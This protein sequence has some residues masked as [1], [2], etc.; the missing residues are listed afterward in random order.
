MN[1]IYRL[2]WNEEQRRWVAAAE[3]AKGRTRRTSE[4]RCVRR[5][6][7]GVIKIFAGLVGLAMSA[8]YAAIPVPSALPSGAQVVQGS[9]ALNITANQ[10]TVSQS[11]PKAVI[12]WGSFDIGSQAQVRFNQ[13]DASSIALNRIVG[14]APSQI[15]G[16]LQANGQVF[17]INPNGVIFGR[18]AQVDVHGLLASTLDLADADFMAGRLKFSGQARSVRNDGA[19]RTDGQT[20]GYVA[21][22]GGQVKNSGTIT[23]ELGSVVLA[24]GAE[25]TLDFTGNGL[26]KVAVSTGVADALVEQAGSVQADGGRVQLTA[27]AANVLVDAM[28][29]TT[30]LTQAHGLQTQNG[31]IELT[32]D[33]IQIGATAVLDASGAMGGGT[34]HVGGGW[35]GS[36]NQLQARQTTVEAGARI[37]ASATV[38]GPGGEIVVWSDVHQLGSVTRVQGDLRATGAGD[39]SHGGRI[40]TSGHQL[41]TVGV[42]GSAAA[43]QNGVAGLWLFDPADYLIDNTVNNVSATINSLLDSGTSVAISTISGNNFG[44][45][46]TAGM[47]N[48][49]VNS[50][51]TKSKGTTT[52]LT[53]QAANSIEINAAIKNTSTSGLMHVVLDADNDRDGNGFIRLNDSIATGGG[54][55]Q[56]GLGNKLSINGISTQVGGDVYVGGTNIQNISTAGGAVTVN[57]EMLI[58]NPTGLLIDTGTGSVTFNGIVNSG[59][60]FTM[61]PIIGT[62]TWMNAANLAKGNTAGGSA[63]GDTYLATITSRLEDQVAIKLTQPTV[64]GTAFTE[65]WLGGQRVIGLRDANGVSTD[66]SWRWVT[67]PEGM[68]DSGGL[69]FFNQTPQV[70]NSIYTGGGA[71]VAGRYSHWATTTSNPAATMTQPDNYAC[72]TGVLCFIGKSLPSPTMESYL[73]LNWGNGLWNDLPISWVPITNYI[74]ETNLAKSPLTIKTGGAVTF[75][76]DVGQ[77]NPLQSLNV[78]ANTIQVHGAV[79]TEG[80]QLWTS[81]GATTLVNGAVLASNAT[82]ANAVTL[83]AGSVVNNAGQTAISTP[84]GS[85]QIWSTSPTQDIRGGLELLANFKQYNAT[86]GKTSPMQT[87]GNGLF[88]SVAPQLTPI[89]SGTA[90][91]V[92]D[93]LTVAPV[94]QLTLGSSGNIDGDVITLS[95]GAADF[96]LAGTP[97]KNAGTWDVTE[98]GLVL[99]KASNGTSTTVYGYQMP[100]TSV[101]APRAGQITPKPVTVSGITAANRVYDGSTTATVNT[102]GAIGFLPGDAVMVT[103][104]GTFAS[105]AAGPQVVVHL[106]NAYAGADVPNY[107]ITDQLATTAAILA[108]PMIASSTVLPSFGTGTML[109]D[110]ASSG[111]TGNGSATTTTADRSDDKGHDKDSPHPATSHPSKENDGNDADRDKNKQPPQT[112]NLGGNNT[113]VIH[114]TAV[115]AGTALNQA[116]SAEGLVIAGPPAPSSGQGPTIP[117]SSRVVPLS[118]HLTESRPVTVEPPPMAAIPQMGIS[119]MSSMLASAQALFAPLGGGSNAMR[120]LPVIEDQGVSSKSNQVVLD[121]SQELTENDF[122][123]QVSVQR[124]ERSSGRGDPTSGS[125]TAEDLPA[126]SS[127]VLEAASVVSGASPVAHR[128]HQ[129]WSASVGQQ[130]DNGIQAIADRTGLSPAT[131]K[132]AAATTTMGVFAGMVKVGA[133]MAMRSGVRKGVMFLLEQLG[134]TAVV[135]RKLMQGLERIGFANPVRRGVVRVRRSAPIRWKNAI[136]Q[137]LFALVRRRKDQRSAD[138][139]NQSTTF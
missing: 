38:Q 13:P 47:G 6:V 113:L 35:Q 54:Y 104:T 108:A 105:S 70:V 106:T 59:N 103:S 44:L 80:T 53:M 14:S 65:V 120:V 24:A 116:A 101:T 100:A 112:V 97:T 74:R 34:V 19:I 30:G 133:K 78:T 130:I 139:V 122:A 118:V 75:N 48:I 88:Y 7:A 51:L 81:S 40:E 43:G 134:I 99:S 41:D 69:R 138:A 33:V 66:W 12:N 25:M 61:K 50:P 82:L 64:A 29:N 49:V 68:L 89:L 137:R 136:S 46:G 76:Q 57:G 91:K 79:S 11:T 3:M 52:T 98:S 36:G 31:E 119:V 45:V 28:I 123:Q 93:Q 102:A 110:Q 107:T 5:K 109:G 67:G 42:T 117:S 2:V 72:A 17:V 1:H 77:I 135:L 32:A 23:A 83:V 8:A 87:S 4:I 62:T 92:Y 60:D 18:G 21:L 131:V 10:L 71:A 126:A 86:Y 128:E 111:G 85:W 63:V 132:T 129:D 55:I 114:P 96:T 73:Q 39:G 58:A 22:L 56:F 26:L 27:Q 9:A 15:D 121:D 115:Q 95:Y 84:N 37:D 124:P 16:L 20:G 127:D 94:G 125:V 90:S